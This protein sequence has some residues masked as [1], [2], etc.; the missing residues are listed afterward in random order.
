M[1]VQNETTAP[2]GGGGRAFFHLLHPFIYVTH[3]VPFC[4][5]LATPKRFGLTSELVKRDRNVLLRPRVVLMR[6]GE[7]ALFVLFCRL[8]GPQLRAYPNFSDS[9]VEAVSETQGV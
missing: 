5:S 8:T 9:F 2:G 1:E 3:P 6:D 4:C 7:E